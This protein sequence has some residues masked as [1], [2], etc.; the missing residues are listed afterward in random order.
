MPVFKYVAAAATTTAPSLTNYDSESDTWNTQYDYE[1]YNG[2]ELIARGDHG[3][4]KFTINGVE[5]T[6]ATASGGSTYTSTTALGTF[7][8]T[9]L[10]LLSYIDQGK[11]YYAIYDW[12]GTVVKGFT[13]LRG[14]DALTG[15]HYNGEGDV[16]LQY[17]SAG[18]TYYSAIDS[19]FNGPPVAKTDA[20]ATSEANQVATAAVSSLGSDPSGQTISITGTISV[21]EIETSDESSGSAIAIKNADGNLM[22]IYTGVLAEGETAT[23]PVSFAITDG[24]A[25]DSDGLLTVTFSGT[26]AQTVSLTLKQAE[27][28][29]SAGYDTFVEIGGSIDGFSL[30]GNDATLT[31]LTSTKLT[32]LASLGVTAL[33][34]T[35][36]TLTVT[37]DQMELIT[38]NGIGFTDADA[39]TVTAAASDLSALDPEAIAA[40]G[41][42]FVDTIDIASNAVTLSLTQVNALIDNDI[43]LAPEDVITITLTADDVIDFDADDLAALAAAGGKK[44]DLT[45]GTFTT[46]SSQ[47]ELVADGGFGF[48]KSDTL[49]MSTSVAEV[50]AF[51]KKELVAFAKMGVDYLDFWDGPKLVTKAFV[52]RIIKSGL[53]LKDDDDLRY[54]TEKNDSIMGSYDDDKID[55][56]AGNDYLN[57]YNGA[58]T[59]IGGKGNDT[60]LGD[61][62]ADILNGGVGKD[63]LTGGAGVDTFVFQKNSGKDIIYDFNASSEDIYEHD[64]IDLSAFKGINRMSDLHIKSSHG[65]VIITIDK[66]TQ[67]T[68][69]D[70]DIKLIDKTDFAF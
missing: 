59:L 67:V 11:I 42:S 36:G 54:P 64:V 20:V 45:S 12:A 53:A 8:G 13:A 24:A 50:A 47:M 37:F 63:K 68:L 16:I 34:A 29:I 41:A 66:A 48:V 70:V 58:D 18:K 19:G 62:G 14:A 51:S 9:S 56:L 6:H 49:V 52:D 27:A 55:G 2:T 28:L 60:I 15:V 65:D 1:L 22:V 3:D 32:A 4:F 44:F 46:N 23:V 35:D 31:G 57:G 10:F 30:A 39:V 25:T 21:G 5:R 69:D 43:S 26:G 17:K 40:L 7:D 33:D 38:G 61:W